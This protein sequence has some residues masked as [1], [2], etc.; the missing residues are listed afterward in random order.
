M[1]PLC[2]PKAVGGELDYIADAIRRR[3][4]SGDGEY[5]SRCRKW[6]ERQTQAK[7]ALLTHS[8]TARSK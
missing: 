4:L 6:I 1:I 3:R 2:E 5:T 8:C 7:L